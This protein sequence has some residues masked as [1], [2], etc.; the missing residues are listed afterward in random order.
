LNRTCSECGNRVFSI[1]DLDCPKCG[2]PIN[3]APT[4]KE[5]ETHR[6]KRLRAG[7]TDE[8]RQREEDKIFAL[9]MTLL[10]LREENAELR[11]RLTT[12]RLRDR[13]IGRPVGSSVTAD[14]L[15]PAL[16]RLKANRVRLSQ[17]ALADESGI[18]LST[19]TDFLAR[20]PGLW[21]RIQTHYRSR[22]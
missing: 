14:D 19:L 11:G 22:K 10:K 20:H 16:A 13:P 18:P 3:A 7:W 5:R 15:V 2:A 4:S 12:N 21:R 9:Q 8:D 1:D 17:R 6:R